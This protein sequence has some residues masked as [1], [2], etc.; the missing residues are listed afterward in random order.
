MSQ[1]L[2]HLLQHQAHRVPDN[3]AIVQKDERISYG[4]LYAC[5]CAVA[6]FLR[7]NGLA[8]GARVG[9]LLEN[10]PQFV[11]T[12]YG[13]LA[14]GGVVVAMNTGTKSRD[15]VNWLKHSEACWLFA[16]ARHPELAA[17]T[18]QMRD[19]IAYVIVGEH[20]NG[21]A[22]TVG[23]SWKQI[24]ENGAVNE[25][26]L[27]YSGQPGELASIIYTSGT[28]GHPKGVMLSHGNL[29]HNVNSIV[30]YLKLTG[31]DIVMNILPFYY[32]YGN[33]VLHTHLAVGATIVL[34]NSLLY[35]HKILQTMEKERVTG[36][37]GVPSTFSILLSRTK[38]KDYDLS[39]LRYIT[40]AGGPMA[41]ASIRRVI[42]DLPNAEFF[43]M[44]GQTEATARLSYLPPDKLEQKLGSVGIGIPGVTLEVQ[45]DQGN[46]VAPGEIGQIY[47]KGDNIM[48]GY[49]KDPQTTETVIQ[50]G[51]LVTGDLAYQDSDG[52]IFI[53]GRASD[54]IKS[55]ANRISP[56]DIEEVIAELEGVEEV[57]VVGI[58]DE[59]LG[60]V[61]KA[62]VV[63][64]PNAK[65][66]K[67][68]V[69]AHCRQNLAIY[70]LPKEVEFVS[71]LP[72]TAS[73]KV[74]RFLLADTARA[75]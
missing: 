54:M 35:P 19:S 47:A 15:L 73:G 57:A 4:Q 50:N 45:D 70:K 33:S 62:F 39:S 52:F 3:I 65:L 21:S 43:V 17:I 68:A 40:Q 26:D 9:L 1:S 5:I 22:I 32:S 56:K 74:K 7:E 12:Y 31:D 29:F 37:S 41:P 11:A 69:M 48:L 2:I 55:G 25:P 13:V 24:Q 61:I 42:A 38:F 28:T 44:Y 67:K 66:E 8:P 53:N 6:A 63:A 36:F 14:A 60:Q 59:I 18:T 30:G 71:E 49:W 16:D 58:P 23:A 46:K 27:S 51:W 20:P 10:S 75:S 72:K 64:S 34:E